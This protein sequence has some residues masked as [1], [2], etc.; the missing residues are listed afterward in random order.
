M[1]EH[2]GRV[3]TF[4]DDTGVSS[5]LSLTIHDMLKSYGGFLVGVKYAISFDTV[6]VFYIRSC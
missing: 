6:N 5:S 4:R 1:S 2:K 3:I